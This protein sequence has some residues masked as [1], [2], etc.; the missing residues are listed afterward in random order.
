MRDRPWP[1]LRFIRRLL[2]VYGAAAL[3]AAFVA[4][5][6]L[7]AYQFPLPVAGLVIGVVIG[8]ITRPKAQGWF[9]RLREQ[10]HAYWSEGPARRHPA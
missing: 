6:A 5:V 9:K 2:L 7:S 10:A 4:L 1:D 8:S 3:T